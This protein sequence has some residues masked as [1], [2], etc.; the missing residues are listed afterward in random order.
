MNSEVVEEP[1]SEAEEETSTNRP[2]PR[3]DFPKAKGVQ[4]FSIDDIPAGKWEAKFQEFHAWMTAQNLHE[5]S[6]FEI[7]STFTAHFSGILKDWWTPIPF[8]VLLL[9]YSCGKSW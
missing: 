9:D 5:E 4:L 6:H 1:E 8:R 3:Q 7:L 2:P